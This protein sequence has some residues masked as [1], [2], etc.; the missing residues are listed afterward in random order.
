[1]RNVAIAQVG[2]KLVFFINR[3]YPSYEMCPFANATESGTFP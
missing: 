2:R 3:Y 1:M